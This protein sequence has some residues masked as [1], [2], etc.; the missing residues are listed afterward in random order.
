MAHYDLIA[1][2]LDGTLMEDGRPFSPRVRRA[3]AEARACGAH[4][5]V[6]T[7]RSYASTRPFAQDLEITEPL[8]CYQGGLIVQPAGQILHRIALQR[9]LAAR[10]LALAE[11]RAWHVVLY[12]DGQVYVREWRHPDAFYTAMINPGA[13]HVTDWRALL[14]RDPD[15]V[16]LIADNPEQADVMYTEMQYQFC[17]LTQVMR[18]H[19]LFVEANPLEVDK[20]AGLAWLANYLSVPRAR[21][22]A[23]GDHD[24]DAPMLAW[25]GLGVAMGNASPACKAAA[26]WIAPTVSQDGVAAAIERFVL[27]QH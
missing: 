6:A 19:A 9:H 20:G 18:S 24:N 13:Q 26:D 22:M 5:T 17:G 7:G 25:A 21:V 2:D 3:V 15:K 1:F 23:V 16:L 11:E 4:V 12:L 14:D 10:V 8:I 27:D